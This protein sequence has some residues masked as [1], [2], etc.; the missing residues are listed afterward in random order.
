LSFKPETDDVRE[1]SS[2][3][4]ISELAKHGAK[5][6]AYDSTAMKVKLSVA[7]REMGIAQLA[8]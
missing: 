7:P 1:A 2:I 4:I 3:T 6:K 8:L 5:I